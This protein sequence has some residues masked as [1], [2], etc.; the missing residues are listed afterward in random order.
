[1]ALAANER[2]QEWEEVFMW[3]EQGQHLLYACRYVDKGSFSRESL[4]PYLP[5][6]SAQ[7]QACQPFTLACSVFWPLI[8]SPSLQ[9]M[10]A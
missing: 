7:L 9:L 3:M 10:P 2:M 4:V 1:M 5:Q 8:L 6:S